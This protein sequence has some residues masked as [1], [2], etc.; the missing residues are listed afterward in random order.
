MR[1]NKK[2]IVFLAHASEDKVLIRDIYKELKLK[3]LNPWL[4]ERSLMPGVKWD[5]EIVNTIKISRF[6]IACISKNSISKNGYI[7]KELKMALAELEK[8][9]PDF[10]YFIPVLLEDIEI[11][12]VTVGTINMRDYQAIKVFE[13]DGLK[14]LVDYLE[15]IIKNEKNA[16]L[17]T[18]Y[19]VHFI[20]DGRRAWYIIEVEEHMNYEFLKHMNSKK[21]MKLSDFGIVHYKGWDET[22]KQIKQ[23]CKER[24][25][26]FKD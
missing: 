16:E 21:A 26:L 8:K 5:Q 19:D 25:G 23:K 15:K 14:K 2:N 9:T 11:P 6:F 13:E 10:I 3:N 20:I 18:V 4:D 1:L 22:P 12:N 24:F 17:N 7:Q